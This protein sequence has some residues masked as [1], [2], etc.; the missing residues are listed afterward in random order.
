[1]K[2]ILFGTLMLGL[3]FVTACSTSKMGNKMA[4]LSVS[5]KAV[6]SV[7]GYDHLTR[8]IVYC[9][10]KEVAR[11]TDKIQSESNTVIA[12]F[13]KGKHAIRLMMEA[14]DKESSKWEARTLANNYSFDWAYQETAEFKGATN[15]LM[16]IDIEGTEGNQIKLEKK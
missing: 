16:T 11:S 7:E 8:M 4:Q 13:P 3:L 10:E 9:D 14:Y 12:Q 1:M 2:K 15:W 6:N 5:F